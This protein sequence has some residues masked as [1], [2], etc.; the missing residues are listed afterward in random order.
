[1][2]HPPE[3]EGAILFSFRE[4]AF[5]GKKKASVRVESGE[6][7]EKFS[8]DVAGSSGV[9]ECKSSNM[10]YQVVYKLLFYHQALHQSFFLQIGVQNILTSNSLTKQ[11]V[12]TPYYIIVNRGIFD[13]EVQEYQRPADARINVKSNEC[14]PW[15][16]KSESCRMLRAKIINTDEVSAPFKYDE[17]QCSLLRLNNKYGG[18]N[19][20]VHVTEGVIYITFTEYHPGDAPGLIMNF[21]DEDISFWEKGNV[22]MT[23]LQAREMIYY[24]WCD[25]A[26]ERVIT[27]KNIGKENIENDLRK[28][29][30]DQF[31]ADS[32]K[33]ISSSKQGSFRRQSSQKQ[34]IFWVSFLNGT[35]RVLLFT[36][37]ASIANNTQSSSRLDQVCYCIFILLTFI[38]SN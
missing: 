32:D 12:F 13:I 31:I 7:S 14:V 8:I 30:V 18:V 1:M 10:I 20:D 21:T 28:D 26:G 6:W 16:P 3:Y 2:Y 36:K 27:W 4:K 19:V 35:Q 34:N 22:N 17:V 38:S 9:I 15:W 33:T 5:F 37:N 11:I 24:T 29:G 23:T 25:P